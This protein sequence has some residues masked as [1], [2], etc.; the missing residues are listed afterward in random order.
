MQSR[1]VAIHL[2]P[3]S[4]F[5]HANIDVLFCNMQDQFNLGSM[6]GGFWRGG[7]GFGGWEI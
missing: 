1:C 2:H 7:E 5:T 3:F 6:G 4:S